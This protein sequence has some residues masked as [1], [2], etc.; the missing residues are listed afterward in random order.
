MKINNKIL[1][2]LFILFILAGVWRVVWRTWPALKPSLK[3]MDTKEFVEKFP[4]SVEMNSGE[5][6]PQV[7]SVKPT[8]FP[9]DLSSDFNISIYAENLESPRV[10]LFDDADRLLVSLTKAGEVVLLS[11]NDN[12][13]FAETHTALLENLNNPHGLA[14]YKDWLYVA[15]TDKIVRYQ[16]S[17]EKGLLELPGEKII[18]LPQEGRH[19]TRTIGFGPDEKLY[20]SIGSSCD[21]CLESD[22]RQATILAVNPDGTDSQIFAS[23]LRNSVFFNWH[24]AT[25]EFFATEMGRDHLGDDLPPDEINIIKKGPGYGWPFCYGKQVYDTV[26]RGVDNCKLSEPSFIDLPAHVAPLG[27]A[28]AP[29]SWGDDWANDLLVAY[30]G[31]WNRST[32]VGYK[33]VRF[34]AEE[35]YQSP[36]DDFI[37]GWLTEDGSALGRPVDL[38]FDNN[39]RL[40]VSDDKTGLIYQVYPV[41]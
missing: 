33:I 25:G 29:V 19:F 22:E 34:Q 23:G 11:D 40:F 7:S 39:G 14:F 32:P 10:L 16:Y 30:H 37:S 13:G 18:D 15:E 17:E 9:L 36:S 35:N 8:D 21:T 41:K 5:E 4:R 2:L 24:P 26:F 31:S 28:F 3:Q 38:V 20:I 6:L 27:L 1:F 12:N